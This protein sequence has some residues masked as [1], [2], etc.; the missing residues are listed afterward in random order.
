M[1]DNGKEKAPYGVKMASGKVIWIEAD[2]VE[3]V[4]GALMFY[5]ETEHGE[6]VVAG[7]NLQKVD[8]FG[9]ASAFVKAD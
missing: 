7:F 2:D 3:S 8:H 9:R 6:E 5:R 1:P 4:D